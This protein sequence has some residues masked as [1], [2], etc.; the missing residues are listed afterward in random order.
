MREEISSHETRISNKCVEAFRHN[1][2]LIKRQDKRKKE[3]HLK[4]EKRREL[5]PIS[6]F[7]ALKYF[8]YERKDKITSF[9]LTE[10]GNINLTIYHFGI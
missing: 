9:I 8:S 1:R 5:Y 2:R 10:T 7:D 3:I 6:I 4:K